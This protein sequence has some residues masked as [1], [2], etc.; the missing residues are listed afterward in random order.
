MLQPVAQ[1]GRTGTGGFISDAG[2]IVLR[3][4]KD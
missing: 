2:G 4:E 3:S 1:A